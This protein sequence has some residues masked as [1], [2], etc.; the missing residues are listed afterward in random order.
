MSR[1]LGRFYRE[2]VHQGGQTFV[3]WAHLAARAID[4]ERSKYRRIEELIAKI[5]STCAL[6]FAGQH[7][8][9]RVEPVVVY[10]SMS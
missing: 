5:Q 2:I 4:V 9:T 7:R 10:P 1:D 3:T 6:L 8:M